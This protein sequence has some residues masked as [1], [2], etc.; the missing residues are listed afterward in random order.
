MADTLRSYGDSAAKES[1]VLNAIEYLTARET[2]IFNT[3]GKTGAIATVH[4]YLTDT[5][6]TAASLAV[7]EATDYSNTALT[8]PSR[9]TNLIQHSVKKYEVSRTQNQI[10]HFHGQNELQRQTQKA[11]KD[12]SNSVEFDLVRATLV[13]GVSGTAPKLSKSLTLFVK[14]YIIK[15]LEIIQLYGKN[16][17]TMSLHIQS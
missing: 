4:S 14:H 16:M 11:L 9:L 8:T 5:L 15:V 3:L 7:A 13:S 10:A 2:K 1:V 6:A 17:Q 12:W